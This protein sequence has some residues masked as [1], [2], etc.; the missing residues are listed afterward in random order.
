MG[1]N[2]HAVF[3]LP[4]TTERVCTVKYCSYTTV[5][6]KVVSGELCDWC[7]VQV[8]V[9][10]EFYEASKRHIE[11]NMT[12]FLQFLMS[13]PRGFWKEEP[14]IRSTEHGALFYNISLRG[15]ELPLQ[16]FVATLKTRKC[17]DNNSRKPL[18]LLLANY[19]SSYYTILNHI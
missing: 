4:S 12:T 1:L 17:T 18:V 2:T 6:Y 10:A 9:Y 8:E 14:I 7:D 5:D 13:F 3:A 16:P 15:L 19:T 11:H